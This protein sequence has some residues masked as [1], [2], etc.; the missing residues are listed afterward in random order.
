[1]KLGFPQERQFN[2]KD[3]A[4]GGR[5]ATEE[6]LQTEEKLKTEEGPEA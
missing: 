5:A 2:N 3:G 1:V 6:K 4:A